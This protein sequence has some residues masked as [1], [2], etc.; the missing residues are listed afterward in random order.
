M[1]LLIVTINCDSLFVTKLNSSL[2]LQYLSESEQVIDISVKLHLLVLQSKCVDDDVFDA[3]SAGDEALE[4]EEKSRKVLP[5]E[6]M[7]RAEL[8]HRYQRNRSGNIFLDLVRGN[9]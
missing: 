7:V 8:I 4:Q 5:P 2:E 1:N 3:S 6:F 9:F